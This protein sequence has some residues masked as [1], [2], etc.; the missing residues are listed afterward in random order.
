MEEF[1]SAQA[2]LK[3]LG[4]SVN[5]EQSELIY[6]AGVAVEVRRK[7]LGLKYKRWRDAVVCLHSR[8]PR[9]RMLGFAS[10]VHH[11]EWR[12]YGHT[13]SSSNSVI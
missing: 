4:F 5:A 10:R 2:K 6:K 1:F 9:A 7:Q 13:W 11:G 3:E 12:M 8:K